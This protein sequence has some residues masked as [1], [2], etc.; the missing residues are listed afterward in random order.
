M[1]ELIDTSVL[2]KEEL[3]RTNEMIKALATELE[4]TQETNVRLQEAVYL[5]VDALE[6][7]DKALTGGTVGWETNIQKAIKE[8]KQIT[9]GNK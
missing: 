2:L 8:I 6:Y 1:S 7:A 5:A 4:N 9:Q 3:E